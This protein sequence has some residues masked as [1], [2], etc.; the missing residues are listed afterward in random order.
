VKRTAEET[1][2]AASPVWT[3]ITFSRGENSRGLNKE[4]LMGEVKRVVE[5]TLGKDG[6]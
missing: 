5:E 2:N 1:P 6:G 3:S 4:T